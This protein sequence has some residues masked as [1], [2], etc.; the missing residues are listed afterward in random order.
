MKEENQ[1]V[2]RVAGSSLITVDLEDFYQP[3]ERV[4]LDIKDNLYQGLIL[5][6]KDFR[7]FIR[8]HPWHNYQDKFVAINCSVEAIIPTWAYM[9]LGAALQPFA[10][11]VIYGSRDELETAIF[12]NSLSQVDWNR[13]KD[14]KVVVKGCSKVNVPVAVYVEVTNRLKPLVSSLMFG[15]ACSTVPLFKK[16]KTSETSHN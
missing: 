2:N 11:K 13:F 6:E 9:L 15:E 10:R 5:K 14:A 4:V 1:I 16:S 3:G 8:T 7:E 12:L